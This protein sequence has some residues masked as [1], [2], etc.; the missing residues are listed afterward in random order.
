MATS[1]EFEECREN[2]SEESQRGPPQNWGAVKL[3]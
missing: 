3:L 1:P 2:V